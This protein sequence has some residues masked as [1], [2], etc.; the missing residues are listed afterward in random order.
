MR[1]LDE[2]IVKIL[3]GNVDFF[4]YIQ[5]QILYSLGTSF[6]FWNSEIVKANIK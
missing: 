5:I 6:V 2:N 3:M 1:N 4:H